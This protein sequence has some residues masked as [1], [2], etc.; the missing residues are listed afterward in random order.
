MRN[1]VLFFIFIVISQFLF[2]QIHFSY[3]QHYW[4]D[5]SKVDFVNHHPSNGYQ[6]NLYT[7]TGFRYNWNFG[8]GQT[9]TLEAPTNIKYSVPDTYTVSFS[10]IIDTIG[11]YLSK[12]EVTSVACSD[13]FNG[14]PDVFIVIRDGNNQ[15]VYST[16]GNHFSNTNP[17][18][19]WEPNIL[20]NNPPYFMWVWDYDPLDANDNCVNDSESTPGVSTL[21]PLPPNTPAGYGNTSHST[22][23]IGLTCTFFYH[24]PVTI[25]NEQQT[26]S[27]HASPQPPVLN[28]TDTTLSILDNIPPL[29]ATVEPGNTTLWYDNL[30]TTQIFTG[31]TYQ[32]IPADTGVF[33]LWARQLN[34]NTSCISQPVQVTIKIF[35]PTDIPFTDKNNFVNIYPN[36]ASDVLMVEI[37]SH[38][39]VRFYITNLLM[40]TLIDC[41]LKGH[42]LHHIDVS[43]L[44]PGTYIITVISDD[45][46]FIQQKITILR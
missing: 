27:V 21:I 4:C 35:D 11:F 40:Q 13:P 16:E 31:N 23:N 22:T 12:I 10:A 29:I 1:I 34:P 5:S 24:K 32:F 44:L 46:Q 14:A 38:E 43:H 18:Y 15:I 39:P 30:A 45:Q 33:Y 19:V 8:N 9:S 41:Q 6:P 25:I 42:D 37:F 17:P 36:P 26:I 28:Y 20:L 2:S 3:H 7:T